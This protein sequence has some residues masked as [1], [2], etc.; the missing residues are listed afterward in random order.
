MNVA[1]DEE[2][3]QHFDKDTEWLHSHYDG[4][5]EKHNHEYVAVDNQDVIAYDNNLDK[6]KQKL[7]EKHIESTD[8][9]IEFIRDKKKLQMQL[10][11]YNGL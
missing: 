3:L 7:A 11:V 10:F 6:L 4:L 9:L 8:I 5:I 2:Q 1:I